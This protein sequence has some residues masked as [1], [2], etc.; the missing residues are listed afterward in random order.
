MT[1]NF[2][3]S[4]KEI[5]MADNVVTISGKSAE[6]PAYREDIL[7]S[8]AAA[9]DAFGVH[10]DDLSI[11]FV[12]V[13]KKGRFRPGYNAANSAVLPGDLRCTGST[14]LSAYATSFIEF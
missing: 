10:D 2:G 11:L 6:R 9:I 8:V 13:D 4:I 14:I 1:E 5:D 7:T 3:S 12:L